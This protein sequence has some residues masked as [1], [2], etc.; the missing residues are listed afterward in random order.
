MFHHGISN[1]L[2]IVLDA[3]TGGT[4][5]NKWPEK[6]CDWI[7]E[8]LSNACEWPLER[9]FAQQ[10]V[11]VND[12]DA[13]ITLTIKVG[14][15]STKIDLVKCELKCLFFFHHVGLQHVHGASPNA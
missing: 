3:V 9:D 14:L 13:F 10:M 8:M 6:A 5:M 15:L 11:Q 12:L 4:F 2:R 1:N 7:E